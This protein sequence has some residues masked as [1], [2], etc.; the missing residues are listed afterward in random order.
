VTLA[1]IASTLA[2]ILTTLA[3]AHPA[4][5]QQ[6]GQKISDVRF[7]GAQFTTKTYK[8]SIVRSR[9]GGDYLPDEVEADVVRLLRTGKFLSVTS[10][11]TDSPDGLVITF[12]VVE[13][14]IVQSIRFQGHRAFSDGTLAEKVP[15]TAGDPYDAF[16]VREG[17]DSILDAYREKG[18]GYASVEVNAN[19]ARQT[20]HIVYVIEEGPNVHVR[21]IFFEGNTAFTARKLKKH[22]RSSTKFWFIRP[23]TFDPL[24]INDDQTELQRFYREEG[25]LDARVSYRV[26]SGDEPGD[27]RVVFTIDEGQPYLVESIRFE[28]NS[29]LTTDEI[30]AIIATQTAKIVK[31]SNL[32]EDVE[33]IQSVYWEEGYI[34]ASVR[35]ERVFSTA[36]GFVVVTFRFVEGEQVNVGRVVIRGN[37]TTQDKVVRR[38]LDLFPGEI[39][40]L[41][42]VKDAEKVLRSAD[43]FDRAD[44]TPV[45][46]LPGE[47][48]ILIDITEAGRMNDFVFG[49]G[50]TSNAGLVGSILLDIKNFDLQDTP[51]TFAEL[52]K[53]RAFRGAGQRLRLELQPGSQL[54]RYRIDF[55][56]PYLF[57]KPVRFDLSTYYFTRQRNAYNERRTGVSASLGR[58]LNNGIG[59][60]NWFT[61]WYGEISFRTEDVNLRN[62]DIFDDRSI[63]D[64]E[65]GNILASVR[66]TVVR[67]RTDNR[68]LPSAGDRLS[69]SFEQFVG[70]H[71]FGRLRVNYAKHHTLYTDVESRKH[72]FTLKA[73]T[74]IIIGD[75]PVFENFF[76]GGLGSIRGFEFR[77]VG[78]RGG[79]DD[80]PIGG[81]FLVTTSFEYSYP[82]V[83]DVMR[84]VVFT[85][86]GTVEEEFGLTTWRA[87]VGVGV[88]LTVQFF[89]PVPIEI[90]FAAP[91][92]RDPDDEERVFSFFI[93]GS[94]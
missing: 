1:R 7:T 50:V 82:L 55:T 45:G 35:A 41:N 47:R 70:D 22:V 75:A 79:L 3:I 21:K 66:G 61:D 86:M 72:V 38:T 91:V 37:Q 4:L 16:A 59:P 10:D 74:G 73:T 31:Q 63:R 60:F 13:R 64:V 46:N 5:A 28:G 58:K 39:F 68:F 65:G 57:E 67:D 52:A 77:G 76:A 48:D 71:N 90:D 94:F 6:P 32:T 69:L 56:E 36:P 83:G 87:S 18:F 29:I 19:T 9:P 30:Q 92:L 33:K 44:I 14:P 62:V 53:I 54:S 23:G 88:R 25:F 49:F 34:F 8:L 85:D 42:K 24:M 26:D 51:R 27:L 93:G 15:I 12:S 40:D 89:G 78:P 11:V 84:G 80:N 20:G 81:E 43:I 2:A 17:R